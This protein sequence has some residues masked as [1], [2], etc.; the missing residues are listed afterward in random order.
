MSKKKVVFIPRSQ[1]ISDIDRHPK[2]SKFYIPDW[3]KKMGGVFKDSSGFTHPGP[4]NCMPFLD[5]FTSGYTYELLTDVEIVR[6]GKSEEDGRDIL[7]YGWSNVLPEHVDAPLI[8]RQEENGVPPALP[9]FPGYYD[10]EFQWYTMWDIKT[11]P[12]YSTMYH[13]PS[14]RFDLPFHTF[15]GIIDTDSWHGEGPIPF[16]LKEGFE[17]I[18]P[19]G[20]PIIQF[21]IIKRENWESEAEEFNLKQRRKDKTVVRRH[22]LNGYKKEHWVRKEFS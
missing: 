9:K 5:S 20:T 1:V 18:I 11:P 14:N 15:T 4:Q 19:A 7:R 12:G 17:G 21:T 3:Y 6:V 16:V 13:H 2:P 8:T 22:L 10:T